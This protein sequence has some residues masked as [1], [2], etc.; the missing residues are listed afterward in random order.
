[1]GVGISAIVF[2]QLLLSE[3]RDQF[4]FGRKSGIIAGR[5][6]ATDA[7]WKEFGPCDRHTPY[8]VYSQLKPQMSFPL[9][10]TA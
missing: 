8:K 4:Q 6:E 10:R 9:R 5:F 1:M 2:I 3:R 7:L